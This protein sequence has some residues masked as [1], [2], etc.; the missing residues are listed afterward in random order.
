MYAA[1]IDGVDG[2]RLL[3][4]ETRASATKE[5]ASGADQVTVVP[6]RLSQAVGGR[7]KGP[8]V[9]GAGYRLWWL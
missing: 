9:P 4:P 7:V 2:V 3:D 8:V 6:S 5:Q 1:L